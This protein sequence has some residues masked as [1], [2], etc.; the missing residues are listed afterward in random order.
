[1]SLA[2]LRYQAT[3]FGAAPQET[4]SRSY[5]YH[6]TANGFHEWEFRTKIRVEFAKG[7][8]K[9]EAQKSDTSTPERVRAEAG[10][11]PVRRRGGVSLRA[12]ASEQDPA[13]GAEG[14]NPD[15]EE[16]EAAASGVGLKR[17]FFEMAPAV[18]WHYQRVLSVRAFDETALDVSAKRW[19]DAVW[20]GDSGGRPADVPCADLWY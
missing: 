2:G 20:S 3:S 7:R 12:G 13:D 17:V 11:T 14:G 6:G 9:K 5:V 4:K 10:E 8:I 19:L 1:M 16:E 18:G 15:E